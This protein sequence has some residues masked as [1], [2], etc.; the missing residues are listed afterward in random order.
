[1]ELKWSE[2]ASQQLVDIVEYVGDEYGKNTALKT[3][4]KILSNV[5][6][7]LKFPE[8]G[9]L[10]RAYSSDLYTV[11]HVSCG[12][13]VIYYLVDGEMLQVIAIAH[14]KLSS[15][16]VVAMMERFLEHYEK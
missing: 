16:K 2:L 4:D 9:R 10:D 7:L 14:S 1:M 13:N 8:S 5:D 6:G 15:Q 3:L 11:R 12:P